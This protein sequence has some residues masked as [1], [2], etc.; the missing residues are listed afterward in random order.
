MAFLDRL[1]A[2]RAEKLLLLKLR[3]EE[4]FVLSIFRATPFSHNQDPTRTWA[5]ENFRHDCQLQ[6]LVGSLRGSLGRAMVLV[7]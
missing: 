4:R 1:K 7:A 5:T 3:S 2:D 6:S